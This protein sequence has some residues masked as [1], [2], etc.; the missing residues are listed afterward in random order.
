MTATKGQIIGLIC[1]IRE[2]LRQIDQM[3][4]ACPEKCV[5]IGRA[6]RL[7]QEVEDGVGALKVSGHHEDEEYSPGMDDDVNETRS[8]A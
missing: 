8:E 3:L 2:E 7:L 5:S 1:A 6:W 4:G